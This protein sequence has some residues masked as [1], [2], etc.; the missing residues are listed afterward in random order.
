M[1]DR[2]ATAN[3]LTANSES[4]D[5]GDGKQNKQWYGTGVRG[6]W[7]GIDRGER[8]MDIDV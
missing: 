1:R 6:E 5:N 4:E 8:C 7:N 2:S 3:T